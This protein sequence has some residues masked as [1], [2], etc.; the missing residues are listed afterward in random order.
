[1][2]MT[3]TFLQGVFNVASGLSRS[4]GTL[5]A[6]RGLAGLAISFSLPSATA[7]ITE[8]FPPG[9]ARNIA[10]ACMGGGQP[11]GFAVGL[12]LG[13]VLAQWNWRYGF[14]FPGWYLNEYRYKY[15][16]SLIEHSYLKLC[17]LRHHLVRDSEGR[18]FASKHG[19]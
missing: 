13:G 14:Y 12:T 19:C 7:V 5:I 4:G 10:F 18:P 3:G 16:V 17:S 1:M 6:F 11:I 9:Q 2:Y 8:T 15:E